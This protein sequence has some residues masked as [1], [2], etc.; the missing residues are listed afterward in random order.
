[1]IYYKNVIKIIGFDLDQ[2]LYPKSPEVNEL[3]QIYLYKK[4]SEIKKVSLLKAKKL[5]GDLY[6]NGRGLSGS[7]SLKV[8]GI[9]AAQNK[10]QEALEKADLSKFLV[11]DK[12]V[13]NLLEKL[14][15]K[16]KNI[17]LITG[18]N[19]KNAKDKLEKL[20]L[21]EKIF[22]HIIS[23]DNFSKSDQSAYK[24]WLSQYPNKKPNE[25]LY[26]GDQL[27]SDYLIPKEMGIESILVNV[28]EKIKSINCP[29]L[30]SLLDIK[31]YLL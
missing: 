22:S 8:L 31:K 30:T 29:Q 24:F 9:P 26:I 4:I 28:D 5:F 12:K 13:I 2:T 14:K 6:K 7:Q 23:K 19:F 3:I 15:N 18:S 20:G 17:D 11:K 25:F 27:M 1:M 10:I 16:Y 21:K